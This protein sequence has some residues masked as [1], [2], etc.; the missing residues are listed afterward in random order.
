MVYRYIEN[1]FI[2]A[3]ITTSAGWKDG[4]TSLL[5]QGWVK[6]KSGE[7]SSN[8]IGVTWKWLTSSFIVW[9][10][11]LSSIEPNCAT[12]LLLSLSYLNGRCLN[13]GPPF[14]SSYGQEK[15][16]TALSTTN[17]KS[18]RFYHRR[19]QFLS[20]L[21]CDFVIEIRLIA[22]LKIKD[23]YVSFNY[24]SLTLQGVGGSRD[25]FK[26][27]CQVP[28]VD[29]WHSLSANIGTIDLSPYTINSLFTNTDTFGT[30]SD[31]QS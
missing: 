3:Y 6:T 22:N 7:S 27:L 24:C 14:W 4:H 2:L 16:F 20:F 29:L 11:L 28:I 26:Y 25:Y 9:K 8:G 12:K 1:H 5:F 18:A 31:C 19:K 17:K 30:G 23:K 21:L 10:L 15:R 13:E